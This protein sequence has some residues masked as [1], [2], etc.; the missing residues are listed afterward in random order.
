MAERSRSD[1]VVD[2]V[3]AGQRQGD[4]ANAVRDD[5][6]ERGAGEDVEHDR[7]SRHC[8]RR[9]RV[10][11]AGAAVVAEVAD[12]RRRVV[13]RG[14]AANAVFGVG[15]MLQARPRL[16]AVVDAVGDGAGPVE[17]ERAEH[18]VVRVHDQ[19]SRGR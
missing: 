12:V 19:A 17:G 11:A 13:V 10:A 5:Q 15:G 6:V 16:G 7:A 9:P 3:E 4:P 18:R 8:E 14:A 1:G 2:V